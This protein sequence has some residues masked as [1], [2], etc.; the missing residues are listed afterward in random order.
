METNYKKIGESIV[1]VIGKDNILSL[2]HC[3]TRLRLEV[4]D[5]DVIDDNAIEAID[6]VKGVFYNAGQYQIILGT[7]VVNKVYA[8]LVNNDHKIEEKVTSLEEIKREGNP[9]KR[10][11]RTLADI[12][13]SI[14]PGIVAT[15]LFL[16]IK[17]VI[18]NE[19]V[20]GFFGTSSDQIPETFLVLVSVLTD[21]VFAFLPALICWSAFKKFGGT[22]IIGFVIGL[23][24]VSPMLPNAYAV[25]DLNSGV[26]PLIAFGFIPIVGYQGSVLTALVLGILGAKLEKVLRKKMPDSLDLMFT[27]FVVIL[28][29]VL[30]GLLVLGP[31]LHFV[32]SGLVYVVE[33]LIK[34]PFGLGGLVIGFL[35][36]LSVMTGMHHL[37]IVVETALLASS[38]F[39][40]VITVCAMY[41]FA[42][43]AVCFAISK[44]TKK[45]K[46]KVIGLSAGVTQLLGVSEPGLFGITLR[47]GTKP[48]T[49]ML[50]CSAVG[51]ALLSILGIQANSYG[52]AVILSPLMYMYDPYQLMTYIIVGILTFI[53]AFILTYLFA[54]P[55]ELMIEDEVELAN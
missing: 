18:L 3:A 12:F 9:I 37:F 48:L 39:N 51:G 30:A 36:P 13:I 1:S 55:E 42:N 28:V 17:G 8:E 44:K 32:E 41:G 49:V 4:K 7:G 16:G 54:V 24:L 53:V 5:R 29:M 26:E 27:P 45:K 15:G 14:I 6:H 34:I 22:P 38:G 43:A 47:Y 33:F 10:A 25:A 40:P 23:M 50:A 11:I 46:I 21:T 19:H 35:Y 20:L 2:T 31:L 52:L